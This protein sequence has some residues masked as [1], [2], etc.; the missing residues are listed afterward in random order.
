[1]FKK[2]DK[3]SDPI[4]QSQYKELTV[5]DFVTAVSKSQGVCIIPMGILE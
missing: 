1:M 2:P 3:L 4:L 5:P